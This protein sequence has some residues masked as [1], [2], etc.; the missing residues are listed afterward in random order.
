MEIEKYRQADHNINPIYLKRWSSRAFSKKSVEQEKLNSIFEA[1][2]WAPSAANWQPWRF[3]YAQTEADR[4]NFLS[5]INENNVVWCKNAPVLVAIIS[6]TTRN[7]E[8]DPNITHAFD[9]GTAWGYLTLEATRQGLITHGMGG[10]DRKKAKEVLQVPEEYEVQAIFALGYY[11]PNVEL[12][13]H[14]EKR[15]KPSD[16]NP[17]DTFVFQGEFK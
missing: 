4:G 14:L 15:E 5:F 8:G 11:D 6:K 17:I 9:T 7:E 16:R 10:F 3:V 1:A 2:R 12:P 13:E